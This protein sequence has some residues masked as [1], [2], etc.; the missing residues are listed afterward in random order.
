[1]IIAGVPK[2]GLQEHQQEAYNAVTKA[3]GTGN[4]ASVVMPTGCGKSFIALQLMEDNR[5]KNLLFLAPTEAIKEQMYEYIAKYIVGEEITKGKSAR[6]IAEEHF[7]NLKIMLY[8]SL[9]RAKPEVLAKLNPDIII[10]DELH[11]TGA[12]KW[13][14]RIDELLEMNPD[15]KVLGLT[16]TPDRNDDKDVIDSLFEGDISYELTLIEA[17]R[18]RILKSP[19]YVKCDYA[20]GEELE[21]IKEY[22][23]NC[24]DLEKKKELEEKYQKMRAIVD[25]AEGI[26]ELF[27]KNITKKDG[28]YIVFCKDKEHLGEIMPKMREWLKNIDAE[29]EMYSVYS[30]YG[31]K[32]NK[33]TIKQFETSKTEHIKL[34]FSV[35]MLNEG[36]HSESISGIVMLRPTESRIIYLQQLGRAMYSDSSREKPIIFD[37]VNNYLKNNLDRELNPKRYARKVEQRNKKENVDESEDIVEDEDI[38]VFRIQGETREFLELL[39]DLRGLV[40]HTSFLE[41]AKKIKEWAEVNSK[42]PTKSAKNEEEKKLGERL[43]DIREWLKKEK[44]GSEEIR[45][46]VE[47]L[48]AKYNERKI[49]YGSEIIQLVQIREIKEWVEANEKLPTKSAKNEEEKN[50]GKLLI[51]IRHWLKKEKEGS[52][53]VRKIVEEL[54]AKYNERKIK[55]GE[56]IIQLVQIREIK[57]WVEANGKLPTGSAKNEEEKKLEHKLR[58]IRRWLKEG[59]KGSE[60]VRKIVEE[61]D[62]KY[63]ERKIKYGNELIRL[64]Q[65]REIKEWAEANSKLP[66]KSAKNEEEK[67]FGERLHNIREWLKKEKEGSEEVRKIIEELDAKYNERKLKYGSELIQLVQAREIKKWAE[68]NCKLPSPTAKNEEQK[69][70]GKKLNNIREWLKKEKEGSE[71]VK[72]IIEVLDSKYKKQAKSDSKCITAQDTGNAG[73]GATVEEC[74]KVERDIKA[75]QK[76]KEV[77]H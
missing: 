54:D 69:K 72:Q 76:T 38:D 46:I 3:Y 48:D 40:G 43:H 21:D 33:E 65:A 17:M 51:R 31:S 64:V 16:A 37:L 26:P 60:E 27:E 63:N 62:A 71:E 75:M 39:E 53:E 66:I 42:L 14:E 56:E 5:D 74:D 15:A 12:D 32:T 70:L 30:G 45:K 59:K 29:P 25:R 57:E 44:E 35:D 58:D 36:L 28:K 22:I 19:Q 34:L 11:R 67:K 9:L 6:K 18:R 49:K 77:T 23:D 7:P 68:T 4:R 24:D 55:Y 2:L 20:L 61:L 41:S 8:P 10:M 1:M 73:I 13:G 52:E 50:L 47:E